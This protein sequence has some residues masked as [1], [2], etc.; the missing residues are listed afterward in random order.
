MN[1]ENPFTIDAERLKEI[2]RYEN[3]YNITGAILVRMEELGI[4]QARLSKSLAMTPGNIS[5]I[6]KG[7]RNF[8]ID[9]LFEIAQV[10]NSEISVVL[11]PVVGSTYYT[12]SFKSNNVIPNSVVCEEAPKN[13]VAFNKATVKIA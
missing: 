10:L 4:T 12:S 6:L 7:D 11:E 9:T 2:K 1:H 13:T 8:T 5:R 3:R